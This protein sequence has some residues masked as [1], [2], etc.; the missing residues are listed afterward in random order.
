[1]RG[2]LESKKGPARDVVLLNSGAA[3]YISGTAGTIQDGI[4]LAAE[5]IDSGKA[6]RKLAELVEMTNAA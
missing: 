2:V 4:R 6:R 5:S 3:L 1:V